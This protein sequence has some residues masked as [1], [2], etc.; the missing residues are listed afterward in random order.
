M[1]EGET[2]ELT[3]TVE[4]NLVLDNVIWTQGGMMLMSG[5][6]RITIVNSDLDPPNATSTLTRT[7]IDR[8]S[9]GGSYVVNATNRAGSSTATF[10][11][12]VTCKNTYAYNRTQ[13]Y[14][15]PLFHRSSR[16]ECVS[17]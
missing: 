10:T 14:Y 8:L 2:L 11:V 1:V 6:D 9:D 17:H 13:L 5:T 4:F 7:S 15:V 12:D 3:V 16:R